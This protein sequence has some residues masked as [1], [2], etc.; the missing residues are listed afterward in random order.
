MLVS[1]EFRDG[2]ID[3]EG[4]DIIGPFTF[5]GRYDLK[6]G[7]CVLKKQYLHAHSVQYEGVS[8]GADLWLWGVWNV[9]GDRGGFHL[10]PEGEADPTQKRTAEEIELPREK[11]RQ[12]VP[13]DLLPF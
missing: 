13:A 12:R 3:G 7:R 4:G 1:L 8:E 2:R 6:T 11:T 10:W 5:K 9:G